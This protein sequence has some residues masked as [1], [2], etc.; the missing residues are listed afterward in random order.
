MNNPNTPNI[1]IKLSSDGDF[2]AVSTYCRRY[3]HR[4]RFLI[5]KEQ[6]KSLLS[7]DAG[8]LYDADCGNHVSILNYN[9]R[10]HI[11]FD[12]LTEFPDDTLK[13][14]RQRMEVPCK[15]FA[16]LM[17]T[18]ES[19]RYLYCPQP[20]QAHINAIPAA[21]AIREIQESAVARSAL[22]KAMRDNFHWPSEEVTLY[23]DHGKSFFFETSSGCPVNGGLILHKTT[24]CTSVGVKPKLYYAVHT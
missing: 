16:V 4:G 12:W 14:F 11:T 9:D 20:A 17:D 10:L 5:A 24:V 19:V 3:G 8:T 21:K 22:R 7:G 13:G 18:G 6:I 2:I 23:Q 15:V 1:L